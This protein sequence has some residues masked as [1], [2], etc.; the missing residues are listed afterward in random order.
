MNES[1]KVSYKA[2]SSVTSF[3]DTSSYAN[4]IVGKRNVWNHSSYYISS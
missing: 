4:D 2:Q 1:A 3:F